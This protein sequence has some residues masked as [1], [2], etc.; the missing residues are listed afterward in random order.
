[1]VMVSEDHT[2]ILIVE[3][4]LEVYMGDGGLRVVVAAQ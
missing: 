3:D 4:L 1:M 2:A